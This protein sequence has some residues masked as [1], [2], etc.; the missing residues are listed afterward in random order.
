MRS[1]PDLLPDEPTGDRFLAADG[2]H[3]STIQLS[4]W[5]VLPAS[6]PYPD[7]SEGTGL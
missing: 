5:P 1:Q 4:V 2:Q 3:S 6:S 7:V